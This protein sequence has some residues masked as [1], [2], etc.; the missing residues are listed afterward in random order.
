MPRK[1]GDLCP[2]CKVGKLTVHSDREI[3]ENADGGSGDHKSWLCDKCGKITRDF[4]RNLRDKIGISDS[5]KVQKGVSREL[6]DK[7]GISDDLN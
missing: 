2:H 1:A 6:K 7:A 3:Y 4:S 5:A